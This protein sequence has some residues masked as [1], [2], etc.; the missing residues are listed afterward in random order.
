MLSKSLGFESDNITY[1]LEDS[2]TPAL[3]VDARNQ[4]QT[5]IRDLAAGRRAFDELAIRVN[6]VGTP[7]AEDDLTQLA[8]LPNVDAV[9]VPKVNTAGDLVYVADI[10]RHV[11]PE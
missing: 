10:L 8:S 3:K 9:V 11:A 6:A 7:Y 2:V 5:H 4:L 1:D